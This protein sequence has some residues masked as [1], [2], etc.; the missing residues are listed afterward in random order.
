MTLN[1]RGAGTSGSGTSG[2]ERSR[3][4]VLVTNARLVTMDA[5][6]R[7]IER[8]AVAISGT[9]IVAVGGTAALTARF[10]A[11]RTI[12]AGGGV[13]TPG[14]VNAHQ[15]VTGGPLAWSCI[16][17]DL[18]PGEPIFF[19][20]VPMHEA[21]RE[22]DEELSALLMAAECLR[23]GT[24]TLV[25]PGTVTHPEAVATGLEASGIRAT[26]GTWAWDTVEGSLNAPAPEI[27]RRLA[28]LLDAYPAGGRVEGWVTLIG[29]SLASD[30]LLRGASE[31]ALERGVGMTMHLSPTSS[32]PE[33]Y[34]ARHGRRPAV[35]LAALGVL[36]PH[37]LLGHGVWLDDEEIDAVLESRT[38]I[39]YCPWAYIRLGQ[40]VTGHG[41]HC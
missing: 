8:G 7:I 24:T 11:E 34:L 36:G 12:D 1:Q 19:W 35:H 2:S 28:E 39:A 26:V 30:E 4:D 5:T 17:D 10:V 6:R 20:S 37:L 21:E 32:D 18:P 9:E 14:L 25:E 3:A 23:G 40:G 27:L 29:H 15:H 22:R 16:P 38:A 33:V 13:V 31:L 41:R